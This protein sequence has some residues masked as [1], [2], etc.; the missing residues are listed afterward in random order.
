MLRWLCCIKGVEIL[1]NSRITI[2]SRVTLSDM[3]D[4]DSTFQCLEVQHAALWRHWTV[5]DHDVAPI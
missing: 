5:T 4:E 3:M 1:E 2:A